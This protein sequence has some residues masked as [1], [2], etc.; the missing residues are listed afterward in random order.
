M[1]IT[2]VLALFLIPIASAAQKT[3]PAEP[4][5]GPPSI[6]IKTAGLKHQDGFIPLDWDPRTGKLYLEI[7]GL[8]PDGD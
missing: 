7:R 2:P 1:R 6:A 5:S 8:S 3:G 4:Q